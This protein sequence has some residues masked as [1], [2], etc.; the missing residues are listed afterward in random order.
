MLHSLTLLW[1][2]E[3]EEEFK[4]EVERERERRSIFLPAPMTLCETME[5]SSVE[6]YCL[7]E[8]EREIL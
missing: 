7:G 4:G 6:I 8:R 5:K 3:S 1:S 2:S